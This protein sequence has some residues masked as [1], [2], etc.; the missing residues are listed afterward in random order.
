MA[1]R[2]PL[3]VNAGSKKIEELV[4]GDNLDL[5][6]NG[7]IT[8]GDL[9]SGKYLTS[10]GAVVFWDNPG[11]VY[12]T[13]PQTVT[14]KTFT[15]CVINAT[16]NTLTNIGNEALVNSSISINGTI[17]FLGGS[18]ITP[19]NNTTYSLEAKDVNGNPNSK[20]INLTGSDS[21]ETFASIGVAL[22]AS[23][24]AGSN[25][26][27]LIITRVANAI[28]ISG[29]VVNN[30][31]IT[32]IQSS[33]GGTPQSGV[34]TISGSGGA[35][36]SQDSQTKTININT[37]N[38]DT[39][40]QI[41]G[42]TGQ[43]FAPGNFTFLSGTDVSI[44]QG[45]D[46]NT[47][48]TL[49]IS[50]SDT[51]T[52]IKGGTSGT[53]Q[54]GNIL[55]TG[56]TALGGNV[57]VSQTGTTIEIDSTDTDTITQ[58]ASG[59]ETLTSGNFRF[60]QAGATTIT[61]TVL[62]NGTIEIEIDSLNT[63]SGASFGAGTGLS[64]VSNDFS[65]KN[66]GNLIDSRI[67]IWD[68]ANGQFANGSI[69]D[70][71]TTVTIDGD[72]TVL[73]N[74]TILETS[75]LAVED[76]TIEIRRGSSL[77]GS[78][79]GIQINRTTGA[80]GGV[81]TFNRLE[82]FE[83]G[84]YW[85]SYDGSI[86]NRFVT[87]SEAQTLSN[88][89]LDTP[90]LTSPVL[91]D[92]SATTINGLSIT[93]TSASA[94]S[95]TS[96]KTFAVSNDIT[97]FAND[98]NG[99]VSV[100]FD[101]GGGSGA[102]VAY[103]SYHLGQFALTTST[104]LSGKI[105]DKSGSGKLMFDT[106]PTIVDSII[107]SSSGFDLINTNALAIN[108]AGDASVIEIGSAA[109]TTSINHSLEVDLNTVLGAASTSTVLV[110]G[111]ANFENNDIQIRGTA[112]SPI[113][114]G[115]GGGSVESNTRV[116]YAALGANQSG[117]LNSA[118]GYSALINNVSGA[119]NTAIG[120]NTLRDND[121]GNNNVAV[122]QKSQL[123]NT[124]GS[125]NTSV[126]VGSL[127]NNPSSDFNV[128]L[129][130]Y[131]GHGSTGIG[132]VIIGPADTENTLSE[133]FFQ[134]AADRQLII[135]SGTGAWIKGDSSYNLTLPKDL[136]VDG[137]C[138][139]IGDLRVDGATVTINSTTL[140]IDDKNIELAAVANLTIT[141]DV[142]NGQTS[143]TNINP[144]SG[145]IVG[146]EIS[147]PSG[148]IPSG[149]IITF[150]N[151]GTK[152]ATL[153]N[154]V[155]SGLGSETFIVLGPTDTAADGGG[156]IIKG[157]P[158]SQGGTGNKS[159]LYDHSRTKKY[160]VSTESIELGSGKE[161][162]IGNQLV[163]S[164]TTIGDGVVNSS[165][166]SVG[167]LVGASGEPALET[168]GAVVLGGRVVEEVFSNMTTALSLSSNTLS[169]ITA[170]ANTICGETT[171]ANQAI[172]TWQFSTADPDGT[173]LQNGQSL[174]V[175]LIIDAS[176]ASTYGDD[177]TVDGNSILTGVRWSGGSPPIATSNTDILT[178]L[179]VKDVGGVIRVYGQGNTDFS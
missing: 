41:R 118:Y 66:A 170:A 77:T 174:T 151:P 49:T 177:C 57:A 120:H 169:V 130:Y 139:V 107:T 23:V 111:T 115:R 10:N 40:T 175:T 8:N 72:L 68:N 131:A 83:A 155:S 47:D 97:L 28:E 146:M 123:V 29:T 32:T 172:N 122:G 161:F 143:I 39:I 6:G 126:G 167:V 87:E 114:I 27:D 62:G 102:K 81:L 24:P 142:Q 59:V 14:N 92:A 65:I 18:Y 145:I 22:P 103:S 67:P 105:Q 137:D 19:D 173:L 149:T 74:N 116:G 163:L 31:T 26:L 119:A 162:A 70:D 20:L 82:W 141:A 129:G 128:C 9:G 98:T 54:S 86:A 178:F 159:I 34:I 99:V 125:G 113:F 16:D 1:D 3:I 69:T 136:T 101:N 176:T 94:L 58:L 84:A 106:N 144:V 154:A 55:V 134:S 50:S 13:S 42:G 2:F 93:A 45:V 76:A 80:D 166:T 33:T 15:D 71:G 21:V 90:T 12:L 179:I 112:A 30:N 132:N 153:S 156:M 43:V 148:A 4:S 124:S 108:F 127:Q 95:I 165:L 96:L 110:N 73:G 48:P 121:G 7:I 38:D 63:D 168:D 88:K 44:T 46:A 56:G 35:T 164:G 104:Q 51:I 147:S 53:F 117:S 150:L 135:G 89:I 158:V 138:R 25:A 78:D 17:V 140:Q 37:D 160:F 75:T 5:S 52:A 91:G 11:D 79:A 64:F 171:T 133:T 100:N 109:G 60:K 157:T 152:T 85:R 36:I 61:Q